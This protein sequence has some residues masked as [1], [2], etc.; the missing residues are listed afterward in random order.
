MS[1]IYFGVATL[2]NAF[3]VEADP[4]LTLKSQMACLNRL[5]LS[6]VGAQSLIQAGLFQAIGAC[7]FVGSRP[8]AHMITRK[9]PVSRMYGP[10]LMPLYTRCPDV[11]DAM[12]LD[13][14]YEAVLPIL[15]LMVD[16]SAVV[17]DTGYKVCDFAYHSRSVSVLTLLIADYL[18]L[19]P[20]S[21]GCAVPVL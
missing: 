10:I 13:R 4:I 3:D 2:A 18:R 17:G 21:R 1:T 20:A 8:D 11:G 5:T 12:S 19:Y 9:R 15:R 6:E 7:A 14:Y 16:V